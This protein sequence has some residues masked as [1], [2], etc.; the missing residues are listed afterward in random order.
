MGARSRYNYNTKKLKNQEQSCM[1]LLRY[2]TCLVGCRCLVAVVQQS[3]PPP[4]RWVALLLLVVLGRTVP[5]HGGFIIDP[6][7]S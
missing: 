4:S 1:A 5:P 2:S 6:S 3:P 7:S